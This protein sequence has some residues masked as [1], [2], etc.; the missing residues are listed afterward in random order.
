[1]R[2]SLHFDLIMI[3]VLI[4]KGDKIYNMKSNWKFIIILFS[5]VGIISYII[6]ILKIIEK[7]IIDK[8]KK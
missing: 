1:M 7:H 6:C 2:W 8:N 5:I 4:C 3:K